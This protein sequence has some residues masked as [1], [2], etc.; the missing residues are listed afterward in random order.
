MDIYCSLKNNNVDY[1]VENQ[2]TDGP[3][4]ICYGTL[5]GNMPKVKGFVFVANPAEA[6]AHVLDGTTHGTID[7]FKQRALAVLEGRSKRR[8][9]CTCD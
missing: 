4:W 7:L 2:T 1:L 9:R 5:A 6:L 3:D 8:A